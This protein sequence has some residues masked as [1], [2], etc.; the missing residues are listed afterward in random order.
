[1]TDDAD[2]QAQI[3]QTLGIGGY[4][5]HVLLCTGPRCCSDTEGLSTWT[6]LRTRLKELER[7]G[8][9]PRQ[10]VM[11]TQVCC[12]QLCRGGPNMVIYPE[13]VWYQGVT[14][15]VCEEILTKHVV[16]GQIVE[17]NAFAFN[18]LGPEESV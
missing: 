9:L 3:A 14:P 4:S 16:G 17:E 10:S 11:T 6:S 5:R 15:A 8:K 7:Q 18:P 1:V 12:L 13:G 2:S